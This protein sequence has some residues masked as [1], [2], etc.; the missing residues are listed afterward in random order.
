MNRPPLE[1]FRHILP[2]TVRWGDVDMLGHINN[3]KY[4]TYAESARLAYFEPLVGA[5]P[6]ASSGNGFILA[7]IGCDFIAQ[8]H[9]PATVEIGTRV[10]RI[11]RSSLQLQH[12]IYNAGHLVA[13][14]SGTLVWF[15]YATQKT[16]P[17]PEH[18]RAYIRS[19]EGG[20][21]DEAS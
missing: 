2:L 19:V 8:L 21:V 20:Q 10:L 16:V 13:V 3:V 12:G 4:F 1:A 11:G 17:V 5:D 15:D 14:L 6:R 18:A 7:N 9:Y